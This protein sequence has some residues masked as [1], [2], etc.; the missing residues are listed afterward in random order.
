MRAGHAALLGLLV[1]LVAI[2]GLSIAFSPT[3]DFVLENPFWNGFSDVDESLRLISITNFEAL[4][5]KS[6]ESSRS[7]LLIAGPS[8]SFTGQE[9]DMVK[10][11]LRTG[12]L[13]VLA[14]DFGTG[15]DLLAKL[16]LNV[17]FSGFMLRDPLFM[18]RASALPRIL[19]FETSSYTAN[20]SSLGLNYATSL[21][22]VDSGFKVLAYS[23]AFSYLDE[24][25]NGK[26]DTSEAV[27]PFPLI[28]ELRYGEG[29]LIVVS[30]SSIF[31][32]SM[33]NS[34]D[35]R[36]FLR[37]LVSDRTV[38][39]DRFHWTPGLFTQ[40]K[41]ALAQ[42]YMFISSAEV[43]YTLLVTVLV[44]TFRFSGW[45]REIEEVDEFSKISKAHPEWDKDIL[46]KLK[47]QRDK[48]GNQ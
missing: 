5:D 40:F 38:Y 1:S 36:I 33:I 27:G 31:I 21:A 2:V 22:R 39:I 12:G 10:G 41:W 4:S 17:R 6:V 13:V 47:E 29:S 9:A 19:S 46:I 28:A 16:G 32:N 37:D 25:G 18:D 34:A 20:V 35:N 26:P 23:T 15:N 44:L 8:E 14:D 42:V 48:H 11:F 7:V 45:S 30:D 24:N 43:K 3:D